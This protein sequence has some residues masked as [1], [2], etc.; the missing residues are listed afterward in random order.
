MTKP[1]DEH[2]PDSDDNDDAASAFAEQ[3][4]AAREAH[5]ANPSEPWSP[6]LGAPPRPAGVPESASWDD[7]AQRWSAGP[8]GPEGKPRGAWT[9]WAM[10]GTRLTEKTY[11]DAGAQLT[12]VSYR[13]GGEVAARSTRQPDGN[14]LHECFYEGGAPWCTTLYLGDASSG[15]VP[16]EQ[17]LKETLRDREG[18]V[19]HE[20]AFER[21]EAG[22]ALHR[23]HGR[24]GVL[25]FENARAKS[26]RTL[27]FYREGKPALTV[28]T[29]DGRDEALAVLHL[30]GGAEVTIDGRGIDE[31][32]RRIDI[33]GALGGRL[34]GVTITSLARPAAVAAFAA[35][36]AW[37]EKVDA[38]APFAHASAA[39]FLTGLGSPIPWVVDV[40]ILGLGNVLDEKKVAKVLPTLEALANDGAKEAV[41]RAADHL[42]MVLD[43]DEKSLATIER[44]VG[45]AGAADA[46]DEDDESDEDED[47]EL[48]LGTV[49]LPSGKL[50]IVD[51][52]ALGQ[53][54]HD[55]P[56]HADL[57]GSSWAGV[58]GKERDDYMDLVFTGP[59]AKKAFARFVTEHGAEYL[60]DVEQPAAD[61]ARTR[62]AAIASAEGLS[63]QLERSPQRIGHGARIRMLEE[64]GLPFGELGFAHVNVVCVFGLP[65]DREMKVVGKHNDDGQ[66]EHVSLV[67]KETPPVTK[68]RI[69]SASVEEAR[70][71]FAD[72][73]ALRAWDHER[74]IDG[75]RDF[76]FWGGYEDAIAA[77]VGAGLAY[78]GEEYY[79]WVDLP[80]GVLPPHF[81]GIVVGAM[82]QRTLSVEMRMHSS[83]HAILRGAWTSPNEAGTAT[84]GGA[85][86][87]GFFSSVGDGVFP[88]ELERDEAGDICRVTILIAGADDED[89]ED[90]DDDDED[91]E[92][93]D[94]DDE[95]DDGDD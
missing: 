10:N 18:R 25:L 73:E 43:L 35:K 51:M 61:E 59:D 42:R 1:E 71:L 84:I 44:L 27:T 16:E 72:A 85:K 31:R 11:D 75:L 68:Q 93:E 54:S 87:C 74:S 5:E 58:A 80:P 48:T 53:W 13:P 66:W 8:L 34:F 81:V 67:C 3:M 50:A 45:T 82:E 83:H 6:D 28:T 19:I 9:S 12:S 38:S 39:S 77:R 91:D 26:G 63:A 32:T 41:A 17:V 23:H 55:A 79:G 30:A 2:A 56:H 78:E 40:S 36:N 29:A 7:E 4:R 22:I 15:M 94:E 47:A 37:A 49:T 24:D 69:G 88:V 57:S 33:E 89:D 70:L 62:F 95:D 90:E 92:D 20:L 60:F 64:A 52:G 46:D 65:K 86:M 14:T 76:V 21:D